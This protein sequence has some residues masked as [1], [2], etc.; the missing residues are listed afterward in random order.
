MLSGC[1][2]CVHYL[3]ERANTI[4][5][6]MIAI[7]I[8][9][10]S[11]FLYLTSYHVPMVKFWTMQIRWFWE[12]KIAEPF[13]RNSKS[14]V[15]MPSNWISRS[16]PSP[17]KTRTSKALDGRMS[18]V[19]RERFARMRTRSHVNS[20]LHFWQTAAFCPYFAVRATVF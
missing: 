13:D 10:T 20:L 1:R 2:A 3:E 19:R 7:R 17:P 8:N 9:A 11:G 16:L 5:I 4:T 6:A 18:A 12:T 15:S 14:P